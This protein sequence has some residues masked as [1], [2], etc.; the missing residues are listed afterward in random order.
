MCA[1]TLFL[2]AF[3]VETFLENV[4]WVSWISADGYVTKPGKKNPRKSGKS[5]MPN[6]FV[7][8]SLENVLG[9]RVGG[10]QLLLVAHMLQHIPAYKTVFRFYN[11]KRGAFKTRF[12]NFFPL[13]FFFSS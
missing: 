5:V 11:P 10:F 7:E 4:L 9:E 2:I 13:F 8:Y 6:L 3:F 1:L 12:L